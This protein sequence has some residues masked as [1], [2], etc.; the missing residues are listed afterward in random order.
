MTAIE[1]IRA[2]PDPTITCALAAEALGFNPQTIRV[3]ART[4]PEVLGFP[5]IVIGTRTRIPRIPFLNYLEG[6][7]PY[8]PD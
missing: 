2:L 7:N 3:A 1:R 5:V 8:D 4:K 6:A